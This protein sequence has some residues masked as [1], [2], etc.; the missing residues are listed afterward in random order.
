MKAIDYRIIDSIEDMLHV[1]QLQQIIWGMS[2]AETIGAATLRWIVH[3][4][5][6][7]LSAWDGDTC[8]GFNIGAPGKRE[9]NWIFWSD[10]TGIHPSY[11]GQGIGYQ[12]KLKQRAWA[13]E[14]GYEQIRWTFDPMQ[15]G[16]ASFNF[17][18][19]GVISYLYHPAFYGH[20]QDELNI[21]LP[22]D[23]LEAV[24]ST[25]ESAFPKIEKGLDAPY[26]VQRY[27]AE[28]RNSQ[29]DSPYLR[30]EIPHSLSDLK[31]ENLQ[32]AIIWQQAVRLGF[33]RY[34]DQGYQ[35]IDFTVCNE[36]CWYILHKKS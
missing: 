6:L 31:K 19:L 34:F 9:G 7:L 27:G 18:K 22:S 23:R 28:I 3:I 2:P 29:T 17:K 32:L 12:L 21:G 1:E 30:I 33:T 15:R 35:A 25:S 24:W 11:Q 8:V 13:R 36:G 20:M 16:N 26:A 10:M 4:G 14:Q 5:G